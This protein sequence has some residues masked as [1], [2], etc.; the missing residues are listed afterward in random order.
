MQQQVGA[1]QRQV[2]S[3]QSQLREANDN[4]RLFDVRLDQAQR[5]VSLPTLDVI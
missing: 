5:E 4:E 3:L 1:L 2:D